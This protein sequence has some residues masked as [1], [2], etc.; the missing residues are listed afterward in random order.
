MTVTDLTKL[1]KHLDSPQCPFHPTAKLW[2]RALLTLGFYGMFR[3]EELG[4]FHIQDFEWD[5]LSKG[6]V[7]YINVIVRKRKT[8]A[9]GDGRITTDLV[10]SLFICIL[11]STSLLCVCSGQQCRRRNISLQSPQGVLGWVPKGSEWTWDSSRFQ[12]SHVSRSRS[13]QWCHFADDADQ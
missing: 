11:C 10:T 6:L 5:L 13:V 2:S 1:L 8:S 4:L 7:P 9:A 12:S 3:S